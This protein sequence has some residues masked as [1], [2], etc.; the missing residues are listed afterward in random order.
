MTALQRLAR[1]IAT[2]WF[3]L[4]VNVIIS[5]FLAPFV[6][7]K[8]GS[9]YYGV[10]A[11]TMQ[12]TGYLYL[13]DFGVRDA[14]VRYASKYRA[15]NAPTRL[16]EIIRVALEV[17]SPIFLGAIALSM[18]GAWVFPYIFSLDEVP[19]GE[20]RIVVLLVGLTIAQTFVANVF[21]GVLHGF[22]RFDVGNYIGIVFGLLRAAL[23]VLILNAGF[24]IVGLSVVQLSVSLATGAVGLWFA[25]YTMRNEGFRF[26]WVPL[27]H[28]RRRALIR[29]MVGYSVYVFINNIGQKTSVAA[30]PIIIGI[31]MPVAAVTP[32]AIAGNL[33]NYAKSLIL[34]SAWVFNPL[35]SH[36][37]SLK[38]SATLTEVVRR[39]AKLPLIVGLPVTIAYVLTGDVF[40]GLWMGPQYVVDAAAVLLVLATMETMSAPHHVMAAAL[41]GMSK[42]QTLAI[43]RVVEAAANI[44]LSLVL[45]K[46]WGVVGV[47]VGGLIPH[48]VLVLILLPLILRRHIH[49]SFPAL[50]SGIFVRPLLGAA[51]FALAVYWV[52]ELSPPQSLV[53]FF[54]RIL[55]VLPVYL[56]CIYSVSLDEVERN[57]LNSRLSELRRTRVGADRAEKNTFS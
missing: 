48:A 6:V 33:A 14:V 4:F 29:R 40:I 56:V 18:F 41:Y 19:V 51:P 2:N 46:T 32:Y 11:I 45:V 34:S 16:N 28:R 17:Y 13:L 57:V 25:L 42:H 12:F 9:T 47:A 7:N 5:F 31:F 39:G 21:T 50:M 8:L 53:G 15:I 54:L 55:L 49:V 26:R 20:A 36:Y 22:Q 10:W 24:G 35:V 43:A 30:G 23:I 52:Y 44:G 1:N 37:A 3:G 38:D 27:K